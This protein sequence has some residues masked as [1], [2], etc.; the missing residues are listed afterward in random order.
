MGITSSQALFDRFLIIPHPL[1]C[2]RW[3]YD[4]I[5]DFEVLAVIMLLVPV[6]SVISQ[7]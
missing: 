2:H 5:V 7:L 1:P 6:S 3:L 4:S